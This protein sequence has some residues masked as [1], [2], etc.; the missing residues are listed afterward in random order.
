MATIVVCEDDSSTRRLITT[1]LAKAGH[2][3]EAFD[4]GLKGYARLLEGDVELLISDVQMPGKD[5]FALVTEVREDKALFDLPCILLTALNQRAHMRV[6]MTSGADDYVTKPF[7]PQE[8]LDAVDNQLKRAMQ[9]HVAYAQEIQRSVKAAVG[10]RTN[11]LMDVFEKRLQRELQS[12]WARSDLNSM[13]LKG[14]LLSCSIQQQEQWLKLLS[15]LQMAD[16]AKQFYNKVADSAALFKADY[17]QWTGDGLLLAFDQTQ[18][19]PSLDHM[20]RA[21]KLSRAILAT[22]SSMNDFIQLNLKPHF[23]SQPLPSFAFNVVLHAGEIGVSKLEGVAGGIEQL[24]A[25]GQDVQLL[26]K[27]LK[28]AQVLRWPLL[29]TEQAAAVLRQDHASSADGPHLQEQIE[30]TLNEQKRRVYKASF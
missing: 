23:P 9:E 28:A 10:E 24:V 15:S 17:F 18:D 25:A 30:L 14:A 4:N 3:V 5:G 2:H 27:M 12:R 22:R 29:L 20:G 1:V 26:T 7:Q 16:L 21:L 8:L 19:Q 11:E 13:Q 6:G